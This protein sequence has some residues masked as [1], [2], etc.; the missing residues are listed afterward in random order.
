[1][2][3]WGIAVVAALIGL[4]GY[5][6]REEADI[7]VS[8]DYVD[9]THIRPDSAFVVTGAG[10]LDPDEVAGRIALDPAVEFGLE[11][12]ED[13]AY[14]VRPYR[15]FPAGG[16]ISVFWSDAGGALL[17]KWNFQT[18]E[19][20]RVLSVFPADGAVEVPPSSSIEVRFSYPDLEK[21][22]LRDAITIEVEGGEPPW[23]YDV[24]PRGDMAVITTYGN[25]LPAGA[26]VTVTV[27]GDVKRKSGET[28]GEDYRFTFTTGPEEDR[29]YRM[30]SLRARLTE[31]VPPGEEV[32]LKLELGNKLEETVLTT[33]V[34][35]YPDETGYRAALRS[36][37]DQLIRWDYEG[38]DR[39]RNCDDWQVDVT[40]LE[41]VR[42][43]DSQPV[44]V[45]NSWERFILLPEP[46]ESGW[47]AATVEATLPSGNKVQ[48][49]KLIQ[50][51]PVS[52]F[53]AQIAD[54]DE[55]GESTLLAWVNGT[56]TGRPMAG[57]GV[58]VNC[59]N[60]TLEG[61][62][63]SDGVALLRGPV[64]YI[65]RRGDAYD[66]YAN[67]RKFYT[68]YGLL[69]IREG[70]TVFLDM[71]GDSNYS[72]LR[73]SN[74]VNGYQG[75]LFT[76]RPV[77]RHTDTV[78]AWG[79]LRSR[80]EGKPLP[81]NLFLTSEDVLKVPVQPGE[82]GTFQAEFDLEAVAG[83]SMRLSLQ[84]SDENQ[85]ADLWLKLEDYV[86]PEYETTSS[87]VKPVFTAWGGEGVGID[88]TAHYFEGTPARNYTAVAR[89]PDDAY[90]M[91]NTF[92]EV[93]LVTDA[94]GKARVV[95]QP[96]GPEE[97]YAEA[98][99]PVQV[100]YG[101]Y[102]DTEL[103]APQVQ[104]GSFYYLNRDMML[105]LE[106]G[107]DGASVT[108]RVHHI[109]VSGIREEKDLLEHGN[110]R[111][112][113][114]EAELTAEVHRVW[115]EKIPDGERYDV[116]NKKSVTAYRTE[117][118]DEV[119]SLLAGFSAGGEYTFTGLPADEA[120]ATY[121]LK[122][123]LRDTRGNPV[124]EE[125]YY[126]QA[127]E[128]WPGEGDHRFELRKRESEDAERAIGGAYGQYFTDGETLDVYLTDYEEPYSDPNGAVL[129]LAVQDDIL[130]Y[131]VIQGTDGI[132]LPFREAYQPNFNVCGAYFDG[133][134]IYAAATVPMVLDSSGRE[135]EIEVRP[136]REQYD[137]GDTAEIALLVREKESGRPA[138]GASMVAAVVDEAVFAV[139]EQTPDF[140][141]KL[142]RYIP[143]SGIYKYTSYDNHFVDGDGMGGGGPNPFTPRVDFPDT[144]AFETLTTNEA[145]RASFSMDI[146]DSLTSWRVTALAI[147][148]DRKAG[149]AKDRF[150]VSKDFFISP[151]LPPRLLEGDDF[152]LTVHSAGRDV[153][154]E[155]PVSYTCTVEGSGKT[156]RAQGR[157]GDFTPIPMEALSLGE[158]AVTVT[159]LHKGEG[160]AVT[161]PITV[162]R[163]GIDV[164]VTES[165]PLS[166]TAGIRSTRWPVTLGFYDKSRELEAEILAYF[167]RNSGER[168]DQ[169][170]ARRFMMERMRDSGMDPFQLD[171]AALTDDFDN[172]KGD[173]SQ[174]K[175]F[176]YSEPDEVL[177]ARIRVAVP[178]GY[179]PGYSSY[180]QEE[181]PQ[182]SNSTERAAAYLI[183]SDYSSPGEKR[184]AIREQL[185][186][187]S[188]RFRDRMYL[189]TALAR[190]GGE[191]E[192]GR[193]FKELAAPVLR[194]KTDA[195]GN[196]L[197]Y[198][199]QQGRESQADTAA[200]LMAAV[201]LGLPESE[202][203]ARYLLQ[204]PEGD[205][206]SLLELLYYLRSQGEPERSRASTVRYHRD[207]EAVELLLDGGVTYR[208]FTRQEL[209]EANFQGGEEVWVTALYTAGLETALNREH[210]VLELT[211]N[212]VPVEGGELRQG[213]LARITLRLTV[214]DNVQVDPETVLQIQDYVPTGMRYESMEPGFGWN[215]SDRNDQ[216]LIFHAVREKAQTLT[217]YA[218]CTVPG[219]YVVESGFVSTVAGS[220]WG[221]S[222]R[223]EISIQSK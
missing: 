99:R 92:P 49:S 88:F 21:E 129:Y 218:R 181:I 191:E 43:F 199:E 39:W 177:N 24:T 110:L 168:A 146:P 109:D 3:L 178:E 176:P 22:G 66:E 141:K 117:R 189:V 121:Y 15:P 57:A 58:A 76:D 184:K 50:V 68:V 23:E 75:Y 135:L 62:T 128:Y 10:E 11:R 51:S 144:A 194:Q 198:V 90:F 204:A 192:A 171:A 83:R 172:L 69:E 132:H 179:S 12:R 170:I 87:P 9:E 95:L 97:H 154:P 185:Q 45:G 52:A 56:E 111:G 155:D 86:K 18:E 120:D 124:S 42:R 130:D 17:R 103:N 26:A 60:L 80:E 53:Y 41:E 195:G 20:F 149:D 44:S 8:P 200:A 13:G 133:T 136:D 216:R 106:K 201:R 2:T 94:E 5:L 34:Y 40:G 138:A 122:V 186:S 207:G 175:L 219:H 28:L 35:R 211:R 173:G 116:I 197:R 93:P 14:I 217:Y 25:D 182:I 223:D 38:R 148:P 91:G 113:P 123:S 7:S 79:V 31:N 64:E 55:A 190:A 119:H 140:L 27:S 96:E 165:M 187:D 153:S 98:W 101:I 36:Y 169:R 164:T 137:P 73:D 202:G 125:L 100:E 104:G 215:L 78:K 150:A 145:G 107:E 82:D 174:F 115:Y 89:M 105:E 162:V 213:S 63:G 118:R 84:D 151:V 221:A 48:A 180:E 126:R 220:V 131:G 70:D 158:H 166:S 214:P 29:G 142:Y 167:A 159:G 1:M 160:D 163:S 205:D 156:Y 72:Y 222:E 33:A 147:T 134:R 209:D 139:E 108:A 30:S 74:P 81:E 4:Y 47:Y 143:F 188:Y 161:Q 102:S 193:W 157:A 196:T 61:E 212:I 19:T 85:Y 206:L 183:Y 46:L 59:P 127:R 16:W 32:L 65:D 208:S 77:Y 210:R 203:L 114:A 71:Y 67:R 6:Y 54:L 112:A 152:V 37:R